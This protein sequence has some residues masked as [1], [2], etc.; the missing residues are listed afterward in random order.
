[1]ISSLRRGVEEGRHLLA[2]AL[3]ALGRLVG[4]IMQ[5]AMHVGV[6]RGVDLIE[7]VEHGLRLL[8]GRS[9]VEI[10]QRLAINLRRQDRKIRPD[11]VHVVGAVTHCRMHCQLPRF[12]QTVQRHQRVQA[13]LSIRYAGAPLIRD[14]RKLRV[15]NDSGPAARHRMPR[16]GPRKRSHIH[17]RPRNHAATCS[18]SASRM[19]AC[20]MPS[21]ASPRNAWIRSAS[22]SAAGMPRAIR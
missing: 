15:P 1:M 7:P 17:F 20:S 18:I 5:P 6:L 13:R 16:C 14:R 2:R 4:E 12:S 22:A 3:V 10:D 21:I 11:A 19:P 8:R 9:V